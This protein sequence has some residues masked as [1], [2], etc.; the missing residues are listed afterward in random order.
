MHQGRSIEVNA[1]ACQHL[2]LAMQR[3]VPGK[4]RYCNM[5]QQS[6]RRQAAIDRTSG[7]RRLHH[8]TFAATAAVARPPDTLDPN[9]RRHDVE[10]LADV[11][12]N[13]MQGALAAGTH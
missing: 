10:H 2:T 13:A 11:L 1:L 4:L 7:R 3:Q 12:A 5:D 9:D 6:C 8:S